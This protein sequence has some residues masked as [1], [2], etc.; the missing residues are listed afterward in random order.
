M[1]A[2]QKPLTDLT[3]ADVMSRA[4]KTIP[5]EMPLQEAARMLAHEHISGA[6][7]VN[8][9]GKCVGVLSA[10][11]FVRWAEKGAKEIQA[12]VWPSY[13]SDWQ[14]VDLQCLPKDEVRSHMSADLVM[15]APTHLVTDLA[16]MMIDAH[17]HRIVVV[18][19]ERRPIGIVSSTDIVAA[20]ARA[21]SAPAT[22]P[23]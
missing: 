3:A 20:V 18:D 1:L 22:E 12:R 19:A 5:Q 13:T 10:I 6:P 8:R 9:E 14:V 15:A 16:R 7:V 21:G 11:D 4:V 17:I 2:T 23:W